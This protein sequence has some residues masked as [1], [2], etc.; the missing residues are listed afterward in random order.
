MSN[1]DKGVYKFE[2]K[3]GQPSANGRDDAPAF[4]YCQ[5]TA[6]E[7]T[8]VGSGHLSI[9]LKH[10]TSVDEASTIAQYLADHIES[11]HFTK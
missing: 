1:I 9:H 5:P 11:I 3:E 4:L 2:V 10:G 6:S 7:L 8:I